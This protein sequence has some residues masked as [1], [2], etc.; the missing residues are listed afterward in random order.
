MKKLR[1]TYVLF[2]AV[3]LVLSCTYGNTTSDA[4]LITAEEMQTILDLE[5]AQLIDVRT[6]EEYDEYRVAHSQNIDFQSPTFDEDIAK[7]DKEKPVIL[8]CKTGNRSA[9]CA[10]KLKAAGFKKI[11]DLK[12]G[13]SKWKH[14]DILD[15]EIKS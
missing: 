5:D 10:K 2:L 9:I 4:Q 8:Y 14:D 11:Y 3:T 13:I 6:P 1:F 7:L 12:G 15:I